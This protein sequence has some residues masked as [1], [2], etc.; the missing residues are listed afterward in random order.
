[1]LAD[2]SHTQELSKGYAISIAGLVSFPTKGKSCKF[3]RTYASL[4]R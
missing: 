4:V 2:P 1:M 3:R